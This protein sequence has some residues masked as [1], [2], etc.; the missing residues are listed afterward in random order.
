MAAHKVMEN[1][2]QYHLDSSN[3]YEPGSLKSYECTRRCSKKH[4]HKPCMFFCQK[5]CAKCLCVPPSP[6]EQSCLPLLQ[7]QQLED[8]A[9]NALNFYYIST[10]GSCPMKSG[11]MPTSGN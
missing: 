1:E 7:V 10:F 6:W 3:G 2:T 4:Y 9:R 8:E 5:C 11:T